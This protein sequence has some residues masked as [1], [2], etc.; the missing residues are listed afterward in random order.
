MLSYEYHTFPHRSE[1]ALSPSYHHL[2]AFLGSD[3]GHSTF[4]VIVDQGIPRILREDMYRIF[5]G[6]SRSIIEVPGGERGKSSD[7]RSLLESRAIEVGLGTDGCMVAIGGGAT[8]DIAGFFAA[9]Y[10]RGIALVN[11]PSTL[12]SMV[13]SCV[14]GKVALNVEGVK[15]IVGAIKHPSRVFVQTDFLRSLSSLQIGSG[16]VEMA[17]HALLES[18]EAF[19]RVITSWGA[20][21]D[22]LIMWSLSVKIGYLEGKRRHMLNLG[23][24]IGHA[25]EQ[26]EEID[27]GSAVAI[28]IF[29]ESVLGYERGIVSQ[30]VVRASKRILEMISPR[31]ALK[32]SLEQWKRAVGFDKKN[33]RGVVHIVLLEALGLPHMAGDDYLMALSEREVEKS[34][35]L[36]GDWSH[37]C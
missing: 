11:V 14:G 34:F 35:S 29:I 8:L 9:T 10:G 13:D 30:D 33:K 18:K 32:Y 25:V 17:K 16:F 31:L 37:T 1:I 7:M 23:H 19:N 20:A 15:N 27:H 21:S 36:L 24:T 6:Y 12:L 26:L 2:K 3:H 5:E 28:G 4:F 22:D